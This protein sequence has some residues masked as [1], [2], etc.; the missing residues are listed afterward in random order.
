VKSANLLAV[1]PGGACLAYLRTDQES[2][3][4]LV[5]DGVATSWLLEKAPLPGQPDLTVSAIDTILAT[6]PEGD[7]VFALLAPRRG[8]PF[9]ALVTAAQTTR[10]LD[11][12]APDPTDPASRL[13]HIAKGEAADGGALAFWAYVYRNGKVDLRLGRLYL[14]DRGRL[15]VVYG[16]PDSVY[17]A[18]PED[19]RE[20]LAYSLSW[21]D[22]PHRRFLVLLKR[23]IDGTTVGYAARYYDGVKLNEVSGENLI[24]NVLPRAWPV[25][26]APGALALSGFFCPNFPRGPW[27]PVNGLFEDRPPYRLQS[28]PERVSTN[29]VR[30]RATAIRG[31]D[32]QR[33]LLLL[34]DGFYLSQ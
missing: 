22:P 34:P 7:G 24:P 31:G 2:G 27:Q 26:G 23:R 21:V 1:A 19:A 13:Y 32:G 12:N 3:L 6:S 17:P 15:Q 25:P 28:G 29:G 33:L 18:G 9:L 10:I 5:K 16:T 30:F 11:L 14:W 20:E 8:E 4:A